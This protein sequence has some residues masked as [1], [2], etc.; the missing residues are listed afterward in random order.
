MILHCSQ[1]EL[2]VSSIR[3]H[4]VLLLITALLKHSGIQH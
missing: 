2:G 3:P 4:R 1:Q